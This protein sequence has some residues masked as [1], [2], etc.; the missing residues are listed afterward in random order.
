MTDNEGYSVHQTPAGA[1]ALK[2]E[3]AEAAPASQTPEPVARAASTQPVLLDLA[4]VDSYYGKLQVLRQVSLR[5]YEGEIVALL[6]GNGSGKSTILRTVS[7]FV[8]PRKGSVVYREQPIHGRRPDQIVGRGLIHVPQSREIFP[9]LTV[10]ENLRMGAYRT[11]DARG[12]AEDLDRVYGYFPILAE[13][14]KQ[15]AG[16]LS[17]GEQQMLAVGRGLMA[18]PTMLLLD[19]PS[20]SLAPLIIE[21]IFAKLVQMN[22]DGISLLI[23]EQ[24][25]S[26]ALSIADYVYVL[27]DG[28]IA[29]EGTADVLQQG[30]TLQQAY[31]G[32]T[33]KTR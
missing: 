3:L 20:A 33:T 15:Y 28:R 14:A 5:A 22:A 7:G 6:G 32:N 10:L 1:Q 30:E 23:V 21:S 26:A 12:M 29:T 4:D 31:L 19:E 9:K 13:R 8:H 2:A 17:G 18:R 27:R 11:R 24:N 16:Y 25:V